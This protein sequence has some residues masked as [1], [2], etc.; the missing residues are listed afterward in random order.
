RGD[1]EGAVARV[2]ADVRRELQS[3]GDIELVA[4]PDA[5]RMIRIVV[6]GGSPFW[7]A[8]TLVTERYDRETL[9]VLGIEDDDTANKMMSLQIVNDHQVVTGTD[10]SD[11]A[12]RLVATLNGGILTRLRR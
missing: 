5:T 1:N 6:A 12:K 3:L 8:S 4:S 2:V 11:V 9:M 10:V 7:A